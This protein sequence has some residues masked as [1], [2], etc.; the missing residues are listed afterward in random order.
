MLQYSSIYFFRGCV[1]Y[2]GSLYNLCKINSGDIFEMDGYIRP[3]IV[4]DIWHICIS[5]DASL[6]K[7]SILCDNIKKNLYMPLHVQ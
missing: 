7:L 4:E 6:K 5:K 1:L 2:V 3:E